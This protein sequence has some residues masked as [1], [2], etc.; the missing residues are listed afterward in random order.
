M[1]KTNLTSQI[2]LVLAGEQPPHLVIASLIVGAVI[3]ISIG[4]AV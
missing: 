4:M 3:G 1:F 2:I